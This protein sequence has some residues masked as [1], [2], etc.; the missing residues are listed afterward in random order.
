MPTVDDVVQT[1]RIIL[2]WCLDVWNTCPRGYGITLMPVAMVAQN[3]MTMMIGC[4]VHNKDTG[5]TG[6]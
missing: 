1:I 6:L 3:P 2:Q 5:C 4:W